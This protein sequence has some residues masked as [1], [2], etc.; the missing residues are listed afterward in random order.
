MRSNR[1]ANVITLIKETINS[2]DFIEKYKYS[3]EDFTRKSPLD[4]PTLFSFITNLLRSSNQHEL[5]EFFRL[6]NGNELPDL[7][8]TGSAFSQA[9]KKLNYQAFCEVISILCH[10]FYQSDPWKTWLGFRLLAIDGTAIKIKEADDYCKQFFG[11]IDNGSET[12]YALARISQCYDVLNHIT[13]SAGIGP[14]SIGEREMALEHLAAIE[15][16]NDLILLDRGYPGFC[17]F[18]QL[19]NS[20]R[21]FCARA[22]VGSWTSITKPFLESG[23]TERIVDYVPSKEIKAECKRLNMSCDPMTLRL[24]RI[25]LSNGETEILITSL[26]D[27]EKFSYQLFQELYHLRWPVE[28]AYK[29]L[30]CRIEIENFS[31]K[32]LLAIKQDFFANILMFNITSTLIAP[33]DK[34]AECK[35]QTTT[36]DYK[37]N[38]TEA[39][40]KM[41]NFGIL[42]FFRKSI[43][44]II[45]RL[46]KLFMANLTAIRKNRT[47]E[48]KKNGKKVKFAFAYKPMT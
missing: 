19:L 41:K 35:S 2:T 6:I 21:Q 16:I 20:R 3:P 44:C 1:C 12:P 8:V 27:C 15:P 32:S 4:F 37:V 14:N 48:R 11:F 18:R 33:I 10:A 34:K 43:T 28:E 5:D 42:M 7:E 17:F 40:R 46:H 39:F 45:N 9:R 29:I 30:K 36:L 13:L 31:G 23:L 26:T 25:E 47:F 38:R 22:A 24:I